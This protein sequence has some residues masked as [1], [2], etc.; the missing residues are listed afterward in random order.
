MDNTVRVLKYFRKEINDLAG[1][2]EKQIL[3]EVENIVTTSINDYKV[4]AKNEADYLLKHNRDELSAANS[5]KLSELNAIKNVKLNEKRNELCEETFN[6]AK[7]AL[8]EFAASEEYV[9]NTLRKIKHAV[10]KIDVKC[11]KVYVSHKD[12]KLAEAIKKLGDFEVSENEKVTI[13]GFI[14]NDEEKGLVIDESYDTLLLNQ[15]EWYYLNSG[16]YIK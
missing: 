15:K 7:K 1:C 8:L 12:L 2:E 9:Q 10:E 5:R 3:D 4:S 13:G 16:L 6:E 14:L 11:G